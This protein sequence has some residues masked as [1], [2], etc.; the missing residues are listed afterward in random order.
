MYVW[1]SWNFLLL[2]LVRQTYNF[3][4]RNNLNVQQTNIFYGN[5]ELELYCG[6]QVTVVINPS[7]DL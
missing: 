7:F 6:E 5:S 2:F 3:D 1:N 4:E